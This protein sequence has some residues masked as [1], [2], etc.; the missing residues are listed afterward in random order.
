MQRL[1]RQELDRGVCLVGPHRDDLVLGIG[2]LPAKG[3]ASHGE[4]WSLA[5]ALRM[6]AF[7][8]LR[9]EAGEA[10]VLILDDVFA[11]LDARRRARLAEM[12]AAAQQVFITAAVPDDVP[13]GLDGQR[14]Q[15]TAGV[16]EEAA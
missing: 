9:A 16:I 12:V 14:F 8:L 15:V 7:E 11:E 5:L 10:P 13:A 6:G 1:R 3:Y 4:S 2:D